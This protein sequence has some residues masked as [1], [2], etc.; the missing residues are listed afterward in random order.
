[1][2]S[3]VAVQTSWFARG[4]D[5]DSTGRCDRSDLLQRYE[6]GRREVLQPQQHQRRDIR[7]RRV[8]LL[9][10]ADLTVRAAKALSTPRTRIRTAPAITPLNSTSL[11]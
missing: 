8:Q 10:I 3:R 5:R 2:R 1:M 6:I 11:P 7:S 9:S 4:S